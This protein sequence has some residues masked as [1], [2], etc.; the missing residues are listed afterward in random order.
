MALSD[1]LQIEKYVHPEMIKHELK[2]VI[3]GC[4]ISEG[5]FSSESPGTLVDQQWNHMDQ[6]H[7]ETIHHAYFGA[8]R[9][10]SGR[11]FAISATRFKNIPLFIPMIDMRITETMSYQVFTVFGLIWCHQVSRSTEFE[12]GVRLNV[13]WITASHWLLKPLHRIFNRML[14]G[15]HKKQYGE[16]LPV[17]ARRS[18][19]RKKNVHFETDNPNYLNSNRLTDHVIFP[20]GTF[21]AGLPVLAAGQR[22]VINLGP[23]EVMVEIVEG[24][25]RVWPAICS[26][27]GALM[28]E[29]DLCKGALVCPWH[30]RKFPA[31]VLD[32]AGKK[33]MRLCNGQISLKGTTLEMVVEKAVSTSAMS[34][35]EMN[36][37]SGASSQQNVTV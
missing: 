20:V 14:F 1:P 23:T 7:R 18:E 19:L 8:I 31:T 25:A 36:N 16:D 11:D 32:S 34:R 26:H 37:D 30:L 27:E 6:A 21:K 10:A 29:K 22:Q 15:I 3:P 17:R 12:G 4:T 28:T 35:V 13:N 2:K 24:G 33:S 9:I 5:A